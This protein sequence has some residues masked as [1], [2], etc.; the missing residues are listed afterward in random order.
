MKHYTSD[1]LL[2]T[3][4][5]AE[6]PSEVSLEL[7]LVPPIVFGYNF[8]PSSTHTHLFPRCSPSRLIAPSKPSE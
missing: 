8:H 1:S 5:R 2:S 6:V 4:T 7:H 3:P